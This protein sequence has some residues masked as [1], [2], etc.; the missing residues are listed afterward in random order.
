[1]SVMT[2]SQINILLLIIC[3]DTNFFFNVNGQR[4]ITKC[5]RMWNTC[6]HDVNWTNEVCVAGHYFS[7]DRISS[8]G[9]PAHI[10]VSLFSMGS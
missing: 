5:Q 4:V 2:Q 7:G 6:M 1:M 8:H 9:W 3:C 10:Y